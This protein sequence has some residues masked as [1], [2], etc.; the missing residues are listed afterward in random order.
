MKRIDRAK[1]AALVDGLLE[2]AKQINEDDRFVL[3]ITEL[4]LF[5]SYLDQ[6]AEDFGD[7][8]VGFGTD[9]KPMYKALD[10]TELSKLTERLLP[11]ILPRNFLEFL[12]LPRKAILRTLKN[13]SPYISLH[14][15]EDLGKIGSL[16]RPSSLKTIDLL[17]APGAAIRTKKVVPIAR[18]V[19][20]NWSR[21]QQHSSQ[22]EPGR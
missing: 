9:V 12:F 20:G 8:D 19:V 21:Q 15:I 10:V 11:D 3:S 4:Q 22:T 7:V 2:R 16:E 17:P 13:R 5:G 1:A 14:P 6:T 18:P